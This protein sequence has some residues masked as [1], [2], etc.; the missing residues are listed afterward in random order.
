MG[1]T[2]V[3]EQCLEPQG[4][5]AQGMP[6][7]ELFALW[8]MVPCQSTPSTSTF[9]PCWCML[10]SCHGTSLALNGCPTVCCALPTA[11]GTSCAS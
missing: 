1:G 4:L 6:L 2:L 10:I 11:C 8:L 5:G 3:S 7:P 9:A